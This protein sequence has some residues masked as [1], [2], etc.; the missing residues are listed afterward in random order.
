ML[1]TDLMLKETNPK[2][3]FAA[4]KVPLHLFPAVASAYGAMALLDGALK[5]G[6]S[7][8]RH[9]GVT[10][11]VYVDACKRHLESYFEGADN[12]ATSGL[13]NLAH[14]IACIAILIDAKESGILIDDRQYRGLPYYNIL[15][16]LAEKI[17]AMREKYKD[18]NPI[19]Y[20]AQGPSHD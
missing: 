10:T 7:N 12:D 11:S 20:T 14:A 17:P 2:A 6:R 8:W 9:S 16:G 18:I 13:P 3:A 4:N 15:D 1:T 19:H 5:Y